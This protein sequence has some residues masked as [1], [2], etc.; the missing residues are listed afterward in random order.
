M[1]ETLEKPKSKKQII[2]EKAAVLIRDRGFVATT[3]RDIASVVGMEAA[4]L[5]NHIQS[6]QEILHDICFTIADMYTEK[7]AELFHKNDSPIEKIKKLLLLHIQTNVMT[8]PL[9][10]V[11]NDEW[12]HLKEADKDRYNSMRLK[13]EDNFMELIRQGIERGEIKDVD[14]QITYYTL[15][16]AIRWTQHWKNTDRQL[17]VNTIKKTV[18]KMVFDSIIPNEG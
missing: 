13:Y 18:T 4:S 9:A 3:M 10:R 8:I 2:L 17:D 14:P 15:L 7:M 5:Y 1:N 12:I 6:K 16:S 11:T